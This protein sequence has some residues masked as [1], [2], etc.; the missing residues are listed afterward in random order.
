MYL[1]LMIAVASKPSS[2]LAGTEVVRAKVRIRG[3]SITSHKLRRIIR[4]FYVERWEE[5]RASR[6]P[7][8]ELLLEISIS[9]RSRLVGE[10]L[11]VRKILLFP[12]SLGRE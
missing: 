11:D 5:G 4:G 6:R 8:E 10:F 1:L 7:A 12:E 2:A 3:P 9:L